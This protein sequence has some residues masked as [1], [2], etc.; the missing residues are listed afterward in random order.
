MISLSRAGITSMSVS[1]KLPDRLHLPSHQPFQKIKTITITLQLPNLPRSPQT[2]I[3]G[4]S[5]LLRQQQTIITRD[6][7]DPGLSTTLLLQRDDLVHMQPVVIVQ[8]LE[9]AVEA[10]AEEACIE[11]L[12]RGDDAREELLERDRVSGC[13]AWREEV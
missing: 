6:A 1:S 4:C 8:L 3:P 2:P 5:Q 13:R 11:L 10:R 12:V 7:L 9:G